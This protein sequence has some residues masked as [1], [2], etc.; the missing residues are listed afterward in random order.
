MAWRLLSLSLSLSSLSPLE[1]QACLTSIGDDGF[2]FTGCCVGAAVNLP[3]FPAVT[4]GGSYFCIQDC[5]SVAPFPVKINISAPTL[6]PL[7][8]CDAF[9]ATLS[10]GPLAPG[11]QPTISTPATLPLTMKYSRTWLE[12]DSMGN[13]RQIWRFVVNGQLRFA[14]T[15]SQPCPQPPCTN[16]MG[17]TGQPIGDPWFHGIIEYASTSVGD[18]LFEGAGGATSCPAAIALSHLPGCLA[19]F[20]DP[21]Y[22]SQALAAG[23]APAHDDWNYHLVGPAP[24]TPS[25]SVGA[26]P[27]IS[28]ISA[29]PIS[30]D[31]VRSNSSIIAPACRQEWPLLQLSGQLIASTVPT[32]NPNCLC[33]P[34]NPMSLN[35]Y[36]HQDLVGAI[37]CPAGPSLTYS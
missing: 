14:A 4:I 20:P 5:L 13:Q 12:T 18:M 25:P 34:V 31:A 36:Y 11:T 30:L 22:N 17:L 27:P 29:S 8:G 37:C 33:P 21:N 28:Q 15:D 35:L 1:A 19:H 2:Q 23:V 9:L 16:A 7:G 26:L 6:D 3:T 24:F 32:P 10:V